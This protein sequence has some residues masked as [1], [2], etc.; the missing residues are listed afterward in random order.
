MSSALK[1]LTEGAI[2][3]RYPGSV[4]TSKQAAEFFKI[5]SNFRRLA[6]PSLGL[7]V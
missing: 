4:V 2:A 6:R 7:S 5:C 1:L 3:V